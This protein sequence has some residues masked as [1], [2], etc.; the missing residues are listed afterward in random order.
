MIRETP[1]DRDAAVLAQYEALP[2]P[3][4]EPRDELKRLIVGSPSHA[5]EIAHYLFAGR[6]PRRLRVLFAGGGTGD[7][8]VML[9]QQLAWAGIDAEIVHL[10]L[11]AH[12]QRIAEARL[13]A[14]GLGAEFIQASLLDLPRLGLGRF[15]YIDCCGVLHHLEQPELGAAALAQMVTPGGGLGIM[16]YGRFGRSGVYEL[17]DALR[18]IAADGP[19]AARARLAQKLVD[20]LP[21]AHPF[22]RNPAL[23]DHLSGDAAGIFDLLLHPRDRAFDAGELVS[24]LAGAGLQTVSFVEPARYD[25]RRYLS[26]PVLNRAAGDLPAIE[27]VKLAERLAGTL[28]RHVVYAVPR[29]RSV[30]PPDAHDPAVIPVWRD[31]SG[32]HLA[33]A[34][35]RDDVLA[36]TADGVTMRFPLPRGAAG[37][38]P[39]IDGRRTLAELAD[40]MAQ[41]PTRWP[42]DLFWKIWTGVAEQLIPANQVLLSYSGRIGPG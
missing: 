4:R 24:L 36:L 32:D 12:A 33:K 15:D 19:P 34:L 6:L 10:D 29:G 18:Q 13:A 14:R 40:T 30:T 21:P 27:R 35:G 9:A 28:A 11:S 7:G 1:A 31:A 26:D 2:Y 20:S 3:A 5:L 8:C 17:Q 37:L 38:L 22:K 25:P 42:A 16:V 39:R 23:G 41:P